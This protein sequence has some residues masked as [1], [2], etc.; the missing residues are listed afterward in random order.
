MEGVRQAI[1]LLGCCMLFDLSGIGLQ[2][3]MGLLQF[4]QERL[5]LLAGCLGLA[6][7]DLIRDRQDTCCNVGQSQAQPFRPAHGQH[8]GEDHGSG[9]KAAPGRCRR[10]GEIIEG[11]NAD[12]N[13]ENSPYILIGTQQSQGLDQTSLQRE[14]DVR[15]PG[16]AAEQKGIGR[17]QEQHDT[18][19]CRGQERV[20]LTREKCELPNGYHAKNEVAEQVDSPVSAGCGANSRRALGHPYI[21]ST[22][23]RVPWPGCES[24]LSFQ[25]SSR[26]RSAI[27]ESPTCPLSRET[28]PGSNPTP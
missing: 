11:L 22:Q 1:A 23:M 10:Q 3:L 7:K 17:H 15:V 12:K 9:G 5:A 4:G 19:Q 27:P 6:V 26:A 24:Q 8:Q 14:I 13:V 20:P 25:P 18:Q 2:P 28:A 16:K 21:S